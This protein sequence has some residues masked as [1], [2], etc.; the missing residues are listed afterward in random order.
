MPWARV[1]RGLLRAPGKRGLLL[2]LKMRAR[3]GLQLPEMRVRWSL[4]RGRGNGRRRGAL[5]WDWSLQ[6]PQK[7]LH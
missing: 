7:L 4:R 3:R 5:S 1:K 2:L 6:P